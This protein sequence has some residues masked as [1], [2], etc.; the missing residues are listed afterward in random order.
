IDDR[1]EA[2][3]S[4]GVRDG[5][6]FLALGP[7]VADGSMVEIECDEIVSA[8]ADTGWTFQLVYRDQTW[9][10]RRDPVRSP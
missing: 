7:A 3:D 2:L 5:G 4:D 8:T 1:S 9:E 6:I 10:L